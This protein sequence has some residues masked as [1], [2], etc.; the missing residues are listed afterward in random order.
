[1]RRLLLLMLTI[2]VSTMVLAGDVMPQ[3]AW[4]KAKDFMQSR[5]AIGSRRAAT[6]AILRTGQTNRINGLFRYCI[7]RRPHLSYSWF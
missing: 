6:G 5:E 3:Q 2:V 4:E 7:E 1:M